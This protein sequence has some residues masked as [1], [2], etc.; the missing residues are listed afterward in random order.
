MSD[1]VTKIVIQGI[2][3][4]SATA[5]NIQ[6]SISGLTTKTVAMNTAFQKLGSATQT[7]VNDVKYISLAAIGAGIGLT[8]MTQKHAEAAQELLLLAQKTGV[9]TRELQRFGYVAGLNNVSTQELAQSFKFLNKSISD[10]ASDAGSEQ[11]TAFASLGIKLTDTAGKVKKADVVFGE[12][13]DRFKNAEDGPAKVRTALTLFGK[14]GTALIPTLNQGSDEINRLGNEFER[15]GN[16]LTEK[17]IK[18][19]SD[20]DDDLKRVSITMKGLGSIIAQALVPV[21][22]PIAKKFYE[23]VAANKELIK[24]GVV[25]FVST[26][27]SGLRSLWAVLT[28]IGSVIGGVVD[29]F[30]GFKNILIFIAGVKILQIALDIIELGKALVLLS[31][32]IGLTTGITALGQGIAFVGSTLGAS[33]LVP[34]GIAATILAGIGLIVYG[35]NKAFPGMA[36]SFIKAADDI[37][38]KLNPLQDGFDRLGQSIGVKAYDLIHGG[39]A[40]MGTTPGTPA[41]AGAVANTLTSPSAGAE[42]AGPDAAFTKGSLDNLLSGLSGYLDQQKQSLQ[43]NIGINAENKLT[44]A[45]IDAPDNTDVSVN[46]GQMFAS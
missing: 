33:L 11:A 8:Y 45:N 19:A 31:S 25:Q 38:H 9:S 17:E 23:F 5:K 15:L 42:G 6:N 1:F 24:I 30:G 36:D 13:S 22:D 20:F 2:D 29:F 32:A 35:L 46:T 10:A 40:K 39:P 41:P 3:K 26:L 16:L 12:L 37:L 4:F 44:Y 14:A 18:A 21:L 7:L 43:V 28:D 27:V 34:L